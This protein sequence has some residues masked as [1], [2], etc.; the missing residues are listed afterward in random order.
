MLIR[1][2][3]RRVFFE[4]PGKCGI[5]SRKSWM[6]TT[7][8]R[9]LSSSSS[10]QEQVTAMMMMKI[11]VNVHAAFF[12]S[13]L[14]WIEQGLSQFWQF[15]PSGM[16]SNVKR[17]RTRYLVFQDRSQPYWRKQTVTTAAEKQGRNVVRHGL[18]RLELP[19]PK[20]WVSPQTASSRFCV[21]GTPNELE[22]ALSPLSF[23]F[24]ST[25]TS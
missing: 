2:I 19:L 20:L 6:V 24:H 16:F 10:A 3:L 5:N 23:L 17:A 14:D 15:C 7:Q 25:K 21:W 4:K 13:G 9:K 22:K 8:Q 18:G 1:A 11:Q 12:S